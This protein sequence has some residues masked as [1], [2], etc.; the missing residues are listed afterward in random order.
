[1]IWQAVGQVLV[2]AVAIGLNPL[3]LAFAILVLL[4]ERARVN[5]V[6]FVLGW[7]AG[8]LAATGAAYALADVAGAHVDHD[9]ADG[10]DM[11]QII[12]GIVFLVLAVRTWKR[13][14]PA[15]EIAAEPK[16]FARITTL[17]PVGAL[18]AGV[19]LCVL[20]AKSLPLAL[21]AGAT[22]AQEGLSDSQ[23]AIALVVFALVASLGVIVPTVGVLVRG[24]QSREPL[25][26]T[27]NYLVTNMSTIVA[28]L[29][30]VI[31]AVL[32]GNGLALAA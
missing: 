7:F 15:G 9:V 12:V 1:M 10:V 20:N 19:L 31:G 4:S 23:G 13:R 3:G 18:V 6:L 30:L 14:T 11:F 17:S 22:L 2:L 27:K 21:S 28:V 29:L 24:E 25:L 26:A 5:G 8:A 16:L 32:I